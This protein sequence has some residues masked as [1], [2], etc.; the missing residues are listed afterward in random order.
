MPKC[1]DVEPL[2][3]PYVDG[4]APPSEHAVVDAHL[5]ACPPC[6]DRVAGERAVCEALHEHRA[7][8]RAH[9]SEHLRRRCV[10]HAYACG[11]GRRRGLAPFARRRWVPLSLAATLLLAVGGV[12]L[13]GLNGGVEALAAQLA[14][15]HVKCF[16][17]APDHTTVNASIVGSEWNRSHGWLIRVPPSAPVEQLELLDVRRCL[18]TRGITAHMMYR[19]RGQPM[20][21]YVLN[22]ARTS[23]ENVQRVVSRLG[24]DAVIWTDG[25]RTYAVVAHAPRADL[26]HVA[27]YVRAAAR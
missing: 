10:A 14:A 17:L 16:Q 4:E 1:S 24:Q 5:G 23:D 21:V 11:I 2:L 8:L 27:M 7:A 13:I 18:S 25:G 6:R 22:S 20:S 26:E 3:A 19:W 15:D 12:F 9:A